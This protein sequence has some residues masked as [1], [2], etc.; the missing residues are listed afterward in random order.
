M[1]DVDREG[2]VSRKQVWLSSWIA[3]A[4]SSSCTKFDV[5]TVWA[6]ECLKQFDKR[7]PDERAEY[8]R[9]K[10]IFENGG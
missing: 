6:D 1:I 9:L 3:V 10:Q 5:A 7:F 4:T 2:N 8:E